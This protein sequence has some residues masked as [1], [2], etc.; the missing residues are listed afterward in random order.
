MVEVGLEALTVGEQAP[1][2]PL[3]V[4]HLPF[5]LDSKETLVSGRRASPTHGRQCRPRSRRSRLSTF[6]GRQPLTEPHT[7]QHRQGPNWPA[8]ALTGW[9]SLGDWVAKGP[10]GRRRCDWVDCDLGGVAVPVSHCDW[11]HWRLGAL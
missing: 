3:Q 7:L 1:L 2:A 4:L 11:G 10:S 6:Q 8:H 9:V 5:Q